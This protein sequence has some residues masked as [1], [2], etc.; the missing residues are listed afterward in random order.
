LTKIIDNSKEKL[1]EA[2]TRE[3]DDAREL[4]IASAYFNVHGFGALRN[5]LINK[6]LKF[7][8]GREPTE[9]LKWEDEVLKELEEKEDDQDYFNLLQEAIKYF[10]DPQREIH[11]IEGSFFHGKAYVGTYPSMKEIRRGVGV[12]GSS[13]FTYGGLVKNRELN[14]LNTDR[15]A[16]EELVA[17]FD[18]QWKSS[19]DYKDTFLSFL[20]NY[21]TTRT[22]LEVIAKALFEFYKSNLETGA[23][24]K[25]LKSLYAHQ[26][27]TVRDASMK[28]E[29]YGGVLIA[30]ATGLGKSRA[31]LQ[32]AL[33]AIQNDRRP[34]LI[35]PKSVLDTTWKDEMRRANI[36]I[37][38]ISSEKLSSDPD[39]ALKDYVNSTFIIV[40]EAHFFRT[41]S[42]NRYAA[43]RDL[44]LKNKAQ[45]VLATATPVNNSLMD[46]YFLLSLYLNENSI[47]DLYGQTLRGYFNANQKRWLN[48]EPIALEQVLERFIVRH[49][50][51]LAKALDKEGKINFPK[52]ELDLDPRDK[53]SIKIDFEKIDSILSSMDFSSYDLSIDRLGDQLTLPDGKRMSDESLVTHREALKK[54]IKVIVIINLFKRLESSLQAFTDSLD[55]YADYMHRAAKYAKESG[56]FVPP[57]MKGDP[58][59]DFDEEDES[60]KLPD[61]EELFSKPKYQSLR[62]RC[63]LTPDE[64]KVFSDS[65]EKDLNTIQKIKD[66]LPKKDEKFDSF[67]SRIVDIS[68]DIK[69]NNGILIFSQYAATSSYLYERLTKENRIKLHLTLV[70]GGEC[71]DRDDRSSDKTELVREFQREGGILI[72]TDVLSAGQNLQNA[73]YV[74]NY[75][76]P[77]N[78]VVLI[79]R[80]GRIDRMGSDHNKVYVINVLPKNGDPE[81]PKSIE[82]FLGLM[83]KL[84]QRLEAIRQT[85]GIDATTLGEKAEP[86]DFGIQE[87][88][89]KND[90]TI[91]DR[92]ARDLEQFTSD[93]K[94]TL[95]K[96]INEKGYSWLESLPKGIGA[97]KKGLER[98]GL[99]ILFSDGTDFYWRL[100]YYDQKKELV[101]SPTDIVD[102][103]MEGDIQNSGESIDYASLVGRMRDMKE[104]LKQQLEVQVNR[105]RALAGVPP[106]PTQLIRDIYNDLANS[107]TADGEELAALFRDQ[108]NRQAVVTA[109]QN[110]RKEGKLLEKAREMLRQ[111][112]ATQDNGE[113]QSAP[114]E[115]KLTRICWCWIHPRQ[116]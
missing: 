82:H 86:K 14:M 89:A 6:P 109:M 61:P 40:D 27:L 63:K 29:K 20:K 94:D 56:Y 71:K 69:N 23:D 41:P 2:L 24:R 7:L 21:I 87:A 17:W 33:D 46:L 100:K 62:E 26:V 45:V 48:D 101:T 108:S 99:F 43:L 116:T 103:I 77:W 67:L 9:S 22:P 91:L 72:S 35:A 28:L 102:T 107:G 57:K 65:C 12:V 15:E 32:L 70:T 92:I 106:R 52:R 5:G 64:I 18:S 31:A 93:P 111:S 98:D 3:F 104:D 58:L 49:S 8:L 75:D 13:N 34:L 105:E 85:I 1:S 73:Q 59:F 53:Y 47:Y 54:L 44:I 79:Q 68:K 30:D 36:N 25:H 4:A 110:A 90:P 37:E 11:A 38:S 16:I 74:A 113:T 95:A 50:R 42:T 84:Y 97:I 55:T 83:K 112:A 10:E 39:S 51:E 66:T 60:D 96:I 80:I 76:F 81:D 19:I 78:P 114:A 88:I 115:V